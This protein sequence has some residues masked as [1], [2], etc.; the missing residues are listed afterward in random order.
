MTVCKVD[1]CA[2]CMLCV[3]VCKNNAITVT[4]Q[5][6]HY[7]A[8]ID[9][10]KCI[11]CGACHKLCPQ[12]NFLPKTKPISWYQGWNKEDA[13]RINAP[14]GGIGMALAKKFVIDGGY[15]CS[16][17]FEKGNFKFS[18]TN[19]VNDIVSFS[20][21]KYVKSNP[22]G[23]YIEILSLLKNGEKVLFIGLPCQTAALKR[24]AGDLFSNELY[25]VDLICHGTPSPSVLELFLNQYHMSLSSIRSIRF[26]INTK[27]QIV[28]NNKS[29]VCEGV[30]DKYSIAFLNGLLNTQNC[31]SCSY[32]SEERIS[33]ITIGDSW[34]TNL[35]SEEIKKGISLILVQSDKGKDLLEKSDIVLAPVDQENAKANNAQLSRPMDKPLGRDYFYS[36]LN[37]RNF[38]SLIFQ[39]FPKDC[40]KQDLKYLLIKL[41]VIH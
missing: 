14:S 17:I 41:R 39:R 18:I 13:V 36:K 25:L 11:G 37:E 6:S 33:D 26:R 28:I 2:G 16:C 29:I 15:V 34:G 19:N 24:F 7:N 21:S 9:K 35:E 22:K 40:L 8:I 10:E 23:I 4:D 31:F 32:A 38:N 3:N 5:R 1:D 12:N 30:S 27:Y 20:G